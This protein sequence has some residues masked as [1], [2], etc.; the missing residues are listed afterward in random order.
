MSSALTPVPHVRV[1]GLR[2]NA[3]LALTGDVAAKAAAFGIVAACARLLPIA[4]FAHLGMA[5]AALTVFTA[6][7]DGGLSTLIVREGASRQRESMALFRASVRARLPLA[8]F[9][10]V[11]G[12]VGGL[13]IGDAWLGLA[14]ALAAVGSAG[15]LT[16]AAMFRAAQD[17]APEA[18]QKCM[19]GVATFAAAVVGAA[20]FSQ[21]SAVVGL[22]AGAVWLSLVP[23]WLYTRR[24]IRAGRE[25]MLG[26]RVILAAAPFGLMALATLLYYRLGI[27]VLGTVGS[28][29]ATASYTIASTIA[30]GLL[31]VPNAITTGLLP[32]LSASGFG[33]DGTEATR[34]ALG[35][36]LSSCVVLTIVAAG[37]AP[38]VLRFG[39]GARYE[40]ALTPLVVLLA[41][42]VVIGVNGIL[43]TALI[44]FR[45]TWIV[46]LQVGVSLGAN[47]ALAFLLVPRF[48]AEGAAF[49]TLATELVGLGIL[50]TSA[51]WV[52]PDLLRRSTRV[53]RGGQGRSALVVDLQREPGL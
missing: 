10:I 28:A 20:V 3:G 43:G 48:G 41:G 27:L 51:C 36:T 46:G 14:T 22:F 12:I 18:I 15:L 11:A 5:I 9:V 42:T 30:F 37:C 45:R 1:R 38:W 53:V 44:A 49:A 4:E 25:T 35:W 32:R 29:S 13:T 24:R 7:V 17:L 8:V 26:R 40:S 47:G 39:F 16:L 6:V 33:R 34:R 19:V 21:A 50:A 23:S 31:M 52:V 2:T